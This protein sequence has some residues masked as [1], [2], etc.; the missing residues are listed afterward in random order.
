M[1]TDAHGNPVDFII[2]A[3]QVSDCKMAEP[4]IEGKSADAVIADKGYDDDKI[5]AKV[6]EIGAEPVIPYR[7][8]RKKPGG[9]GCG[10]IRCSP[11]H[12]E[13]F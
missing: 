4:L 11:C 8:N 6:R 3:G 7:S 12:R 1:L 9:C 2:T 13:F 10:F 5:R